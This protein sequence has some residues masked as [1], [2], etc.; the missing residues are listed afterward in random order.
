VN[1]EE[2]VEEHRVSPWGE[3]YNKRGEKP[4][5]WQGEPRLEGGKGR[6]WGENKNTPLSCE[7]DNKITDWGPEK[8]GIKKI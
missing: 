5:V 7:Q 4:F 2:K 6:E 8:E 3:N 1:R